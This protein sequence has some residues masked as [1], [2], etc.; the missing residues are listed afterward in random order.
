[1]NAASPCTVIDCDRGSGET[2]TNAPRDERALALARR[3][4]FAS[5]H[6]IVPHATLYPCI[7]I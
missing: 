5:L 4:A 3:T 1:L 6:A 2:S 7:D